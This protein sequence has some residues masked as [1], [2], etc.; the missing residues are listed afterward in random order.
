MVN[1]GLQTCIMCKNSIEVF[2]T[3]TSV[4]IS[5]TDLDSRPKGLA[6]NYEKNFVRICPN[7]GY[8]SF[9]LSKDITMEHNE[10]IESEEYKEVLNN[11]DLIVDAK[12]FY[13]VGIILKH[14][15]DHQ[16]AA[17]S[18]L[19]ASWFFSDALNKEWTKKSQLEAIN[20]LEKSDFT[21]TNEYD[22]SILVD[23]YR[24]IGEFDKAKKTILTFKLESC[25]NLTI[26]K[27]LKL[28]LELCDKKDTQ[29]HSTYELED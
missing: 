25:T 7:C 16:R 8:A 17:T 2:D 12:K 23:L 9:N 10:I 15:N 4:T 13:L 1:N 22:L 28:Q 6:R 26:V 29:V 27:I 18:F 19:R 14:N 3:M 24:R 5:Q 20:E 21:Y 11:E